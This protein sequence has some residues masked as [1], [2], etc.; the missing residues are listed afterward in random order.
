MS[1]TVASVIAII[2]AITAATKGGV[3]LSQNAAARDEA[4]ELSGI[5]RQDELQ[6]EAASQEVSRDK[7]RM[8]SRSI[9]RRGVEIGMEKDAMDLAQ[10][11]ASGDAVKATMG[12]ATDSML[13][14]LADTKQ[15]DLLRVGR[16]KQ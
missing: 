12:S 5:Q 6:A 4:R 8:T 3:E 2:S 1:A 7:N 11:D 9:D 15:K 13:G 14:G 10:F 16:F